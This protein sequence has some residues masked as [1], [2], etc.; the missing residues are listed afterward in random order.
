MRKSLLLGMAVLGLAA[1]AQAGSH[2]SA[3]CGIGTMIFKG[4]SGKVQLILAA[5]TNG[6]FGNQTFGISS[7]T[8]GCTA[9]GVVKADKRL[10]VYAE[11]NMRRLSR[12][13]A[14]GRGETLDGLASLMGCKDAATK[15][16]FF[17]LTQT[18][19][20]KILPSA[21]TDASAMLGNLRAEMARDQVLRTL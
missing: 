17:R 6:T 9:D 19:Y 4:Q 3:G 2:S 20:E 12:E 21:D 13:M 5:T 15:Q 1:S 18:R 8:L 14:Q 7:E 16:A 10:D 11:V